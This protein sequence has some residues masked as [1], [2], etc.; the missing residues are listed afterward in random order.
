MLQTE[1]FEALTKM[2][3]EQVTT[4]SNHDAALQHNS[5]CSIVNYK[6][7]S[8]MLQNNSAGGITEDSVLH[9]TSIEVSLLA[10]NAALRV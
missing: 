6:L 5:T 8:S 3:K 4:T 9:G 2:Q 7:K 1:R 10:H